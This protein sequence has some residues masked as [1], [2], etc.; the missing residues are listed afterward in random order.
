VRIA[1]HARSCP[2][3]VCRHAVAATRI[4]S[5]F[6]ML[7]TRTAATALDRVGRALPHGDG[8]MGSAMAE[9]TGVGRPQAIAA[10]YGTTSALILDRQGLPPGRGRSGDARAGPKGCNRWS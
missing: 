1:T 3:A 6:A 5:P 10:T 4:T 9:R 8:R 2:P 7:A